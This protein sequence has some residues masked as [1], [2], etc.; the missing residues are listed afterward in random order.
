MSES[1]ASGCL[2]I[3]GS[4]KGSVLQC[5]KFFRRAFEKR[6]ARFF[7]KNYGHFFASC[8]AAITES[9]HPPTQPQ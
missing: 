8:Y 6:A 9:P 1:I 3:T 2:I 7:S 4:E 5:D